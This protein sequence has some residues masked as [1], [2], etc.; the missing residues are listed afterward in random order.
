MYYW[1][2]DLLVGTVLV[3]IGVFAGSQWLKDKPR[4]CDTPE[5]PV[6]ITDC[7]KVETCPV[8]VQVV[9]KKVRVIEKPK[10]EKVGFTLWHE[11]K[12]YHMVGCNHRVK[13]VEGVSLI[14]AIRRLIKD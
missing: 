11:G 6:E 14:S 13:Q 5:S 7:K 8:S 10:C 1:I 12:N 4:P 3:L 9:E 2:R